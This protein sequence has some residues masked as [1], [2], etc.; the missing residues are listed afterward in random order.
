V[1]EPARQSRTYEAPGRRWTPRRFAPCDRGQRSVN[2]G[3][4]TSGGEGARSLLLRRSCR[5]A[6]L[7]LPGVVR[8]VSAAGSQRLLRSALPALGQYA[9]RA[10]RD[11][12]RSSAR[13]SRCSLASA[14]CSARRSARCSRASRTCCCCWLPRETAWAPW[15]CCAAPRISDMALSSLVWCIL[16][17]SLRTG[18]SGPGTRHGPRQRWTSS[19]AI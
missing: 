1:S 13:V 19:G 18:T 7:R 5:S 4:G 16:L 2:A 15:I 12:R 3:A 14:C 11:S 8:P 10:A 9:L 17:A 6:R